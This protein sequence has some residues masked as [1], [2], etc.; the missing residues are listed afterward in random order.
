[1]IPLFALIRKDIILFLHD[2][3]ALVL[4]LLMPILLA[5]FF[6]YLTGGSGKKD[7]AKIEIALVQSD[8]HVISHKISAGL[9]ADT[10]L[11]IQE[12]SLEQAQ[13]LVRKGKLAVAIV[14][15][16][17]FGEAAGAAFFGT[18]E[19]PD[20]PLYFDPSQ[21]TV[22]AMVKGILTQHVM[23]S[24]S[25]EM[26][27]GSGG[28]N[29]VADSLAKLEAMPALS[30]E[31]KE[32]KTFLG[33]LQQFQQHQR[34][35][36]RKVE[37][38]ATKEPQKEAGLTMP[39]HTK[40]EALN[41]KS[42][43]ASTYNGYA[44]SFAGMTVQFILFLAIDAGI[45]VLQSRKQGLWNRLLAAP[46]GMNTLIIARALSCALIALFVSCV[47][48]AVAILVFQVEILGSVPGLIGIA[49]SFALMTASF[50]LLIAA[51]GKT[52][53]AARGIA[54]FATLVLVML[55][56]AW[57]PSF[58]FPQ[59]LQDMTMFIPT[60]WA[61]DGFDAMT[62]RGLGIEA[63]LPSMAALLGFTAIFGTLALWRFGREQAAK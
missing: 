3:R 58:L 5:A 28:T 36:D 15:P 25:A 62:W 9:K 55:G 50:G 46:I 20:L 42:G 1:M 43:I 22:L 4:T 8:Q 30:S 16:A 6:G 56:G 38:T 27:S 17:G 60:R 52:P 11:Q 23:Q 33:S 53:E 49:I 37:A 32:L 45:G 61:V 63:A 51:F 44:H 29:M 40:E 35:D 21:S 18:N 48:C 7:A 19:K 54:T 31:Q 13:E 26:F 39:F 2:K 14:L 24:V 41:A 34:G 10:S 12:L 57:M 59:W 47:L